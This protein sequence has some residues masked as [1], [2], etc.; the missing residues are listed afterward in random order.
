MEVIQKVKEKVSKK[1]KPK[2]RKNKEDLKKLIH[3]NLNYLSQIPEME[4]NLIKD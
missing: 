2:K 1:L 3:Q 4:R